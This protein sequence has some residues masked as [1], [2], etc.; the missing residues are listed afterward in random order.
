MIAIGSVQGIQFYFNAG[1]FSGI[2]IDKHRK[3]LYSVKE[4]FQ[5]FP[6][7]LI[8]PVNQPYSVLHKLGIELEQD[9]VPDSSTYLRTTQEIGIGRRHIEVCQYRKSEKSSTIEEELFGVIIGE[10]SFKF[11]LSESTFWQCVLSNVLTVRALGTRK[12]YLISC[13]SPNL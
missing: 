5:G 13:Q 3:A 12:K 11:D 2:Q 4:Q 7:H 8:S 6:S 9:Y 10:I 1:L